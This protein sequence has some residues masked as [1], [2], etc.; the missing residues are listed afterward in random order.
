MSR[1]LMILPD[2]SAEPILDAI[3]G[4]TKSLRIKM[5][6]LSDPKIINALI[7]AHDRAVK[8]RVMLSPHRRSGKPE[9]EGSSR[10]LAEA[11]VD[12]LDS[13]PAFD[14]TH[15]KSMVVDDKT[16]FVQSLNW[17]LKNFTK[18]R[19][20]AVITRQLHEVNEIID[21]FEA[22]WSRQDYSPPEHSHLIWCPENG[23]ERF[24]HL[25]DSA[26][27]SLFVQNERYQDAVIVERLVRAKL[28]GV[29]VHVISR[30]PHFLKAEKL[31]EG[32]GGLQI[33]NDVGIKIRKLKHLKLH[34]KT[35]LVDGA[36]AIIGSI[37][38]SPGSFDKRRELAIEV[39]DN[40]IL[41]RLHSVVQHDWKKSHPLDLTDKGILSDL[42]A[43]HQQGVESLALA[44]TDKNL[45][46]GKVRRPAR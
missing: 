40:D 18:T 41:D 29:K 45:H 32:V 6:I 10:M 17:V 38:L 24:V 39:R 21:C 22:D 11:G 3:H 2:D 4:A 5:F 31:I 25:I 14:L 42:E 26:Q 20:Y 35:L 9:N 28:R 37:N 44:A 16:G 1:S 7:R 34:A 19:D 43:H 12:V 30:P 15:E 13:N 46:P 27:H 8:V 33:M 36:R 23:R